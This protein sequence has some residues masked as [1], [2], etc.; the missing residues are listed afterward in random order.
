MIKD[1]AIPYKQLENQKEITTSAIGLVDRVFAN[2]PGDLGSILARVIPKTLKM[3][4][5]T[6]LLNTQQYKVV[7]RVKWSNPGK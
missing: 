2:G 7:S 5:D 3:V 1:W 6:Y 4:L